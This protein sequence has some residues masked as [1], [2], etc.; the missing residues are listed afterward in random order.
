MVSPEFEGLWMCTWELI[1]G[2]WPSFRGFNSDFNLSGLRAC[3]VTQ[4]CPPLSDPMDCSLPGSSV[5][6]VL[7]ARILEEWVAMPSS[8]ASSWPG[9]W[10]H[11]TCI[12]RWILYHWT[13]PAAGTNGKHAEK[14][15]VENA[16]QPSPVDAWQKHPMWLF[17]QSSTVLNC[18]F[19]SFTLL[20]SD[21]SYT[22]THTY[23]YT[24]LFSFACLQAPVFLP[25][26]SHGRR[27][28]VGCSSSGHYKS[29][30]T[31]WLHF[32]FSL[33]HIGEGNGNPLQCSCHENPRDG[34]PGGL[35]SMG[36][37]RVRHDWSNLAAASSVNSFAT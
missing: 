19:H 1:E 13:R 3:S 15:I 31:E 34:E 35:P 11:V 37:H 7:Q 16:F 2:H 33:S 17:T 36:L 14:G 6:G 12:G 27:S 20:K 26:K 8:R 18:M 23:A 9:D 29:D 22:H 25:G 10:T 5:H 24:M 30:T 4:S 32:H 28:L 21:L